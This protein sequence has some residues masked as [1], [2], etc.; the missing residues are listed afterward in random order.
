[1]RKRSYAASAKGKRIVRS[2]FLG[3]CVPGVMPICINLGR[4]VFSHR[5]LLD[6]TFSGMT[7]FVEQLLAGLSFPLLF[8]QQGRHGPSEIMVQRLHGALLD[9]MC[10]ASYAFQPQNELRGTDFAA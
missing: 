9:G 2:P 1:M 6:T 5:L 3:G 4:L 8:T 7:G 10:K